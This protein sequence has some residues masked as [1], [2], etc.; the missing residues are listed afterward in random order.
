M[1]D[2]RDT[3]GRVVREA[4]VGWAKTQASPKPSWLVPYDDLSVADKEAD[5]QIGE[6]L[7]RV[8]FYEATREIERLSARVAGLEE[9]AEAAD[10]ALSYFKSGDVSRDLSEAIRQLREADA[11]VAELERQLRE[12]RD[13]CAAVAED[14][15]QRWHRREYDADPEGNAWSVGEWACEMIAERFAE[16]RETA[17]PRA[18]RGAEG[19]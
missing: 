8:L 6:H 3:L 15:R 7:A 14:E 9:D 1:D 17:E 11:R 10:A 19:E 13:W 4:W 2:Y 18:P 16:G 5:R 12:E